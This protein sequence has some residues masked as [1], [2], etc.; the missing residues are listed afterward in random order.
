MSARRR[1]L[2]GLVV[3]GML[4]ATGWWA[5]G[6]EGREHARRTLQGLKGVRVV[7]EDI[8]P[9]AERDGLTQR[10][11]QANVELRLRRAGIAALTEKQL[12][13]APGMPVLYVKIDTRKG[14]SERTKGLYAYSV[15]VGLYQLVRLSRDNRIAA[16]AE[17]WYTAGVN[18]VESNHL[19]TVRE[20]AT[21]KV[22]QFINAYLAANPK[23]PPARAPGGRT[24]GPP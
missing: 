6:Q 10:E 9:D 1:L 4:C 3:F 17:T 22:D 13:E 19:R 18:V 23:A 8:E 16:G 2:L 7:V 11:L 12:L 14:Q 20:D 24:L 5:Y 15:H 21:E